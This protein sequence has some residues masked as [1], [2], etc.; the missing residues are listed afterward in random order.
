MVE[1]D[2]W[3]GTGL[4]E[5]VWERVGVCRAYLLLLTNPASLFHQ[6]TVAPHNHWDYRGKWIIVGLKRDQLEALVL[7]TKGR[8]TDHLVGVV[9]VSVTDHANT[10]SRYHTRN[11]YIDRLL[12]I[13]Y[14]NVILID[15]VNIF[16]TYI[17]MHYYTI[18]IYGPT[19]I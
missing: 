10:V 15:K 14:K 3:N 6:A 17:F 11:R 5:V 7:T 4:D 18:L 12:T 19:F 13:V 2:A 9:E 16:C 8:K 1:I